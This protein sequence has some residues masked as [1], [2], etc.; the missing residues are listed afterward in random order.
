MR[1]KVLICPFV[2]SLA[3]LASEEPPTKKP[4]RL[5]RLTITVPEHVSTKV[6]RPKHAGFEEWVVCR[7]CGSKEIS[8][9]ITM[10]DITYGFCN[11]HTQ[12]AS[13]AWKELFSVKEEDL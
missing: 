11:H 10:N 12:Y 3:L 6:Q 13:S 7:V 9:S 5:P 1:Y 8:E 4:R 2:A